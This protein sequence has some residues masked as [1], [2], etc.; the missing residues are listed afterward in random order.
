MKNTAIYHPPKKIL[1]NYANVLVNFALGDGKGIKKGETVSVYANESAK[2]LYA[3]ILRAVWK[4]GGHVIGRY[5]PEND[6]ANNFDRMF[7]DH[8]EEHQLIHFPSKYMKGIIEQTDH[9]LYVSSTTNKRSLQG[10]DPKKIMKRGIAM[11]G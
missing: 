6:S 2:P 5:S 11:N 9:G 7:F 4:A 3:E 8:A 1:E 10:V